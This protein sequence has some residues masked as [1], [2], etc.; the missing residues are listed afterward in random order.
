MSASGGSS[1]ATIAGCS[2]AAAAV[3][4]SLLVVLLVKIRSKKH[5]IS[6][7]ES[8]NFERK[9]FESPNNFSMGFSTTN[10]NED[11]FAED[12]KEDKFID[13]I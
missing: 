6:A 8:D 5:A 3:V 7:Q 13:Q 4:V 11:P 10:V 12:F 9:D 2:A 1:A